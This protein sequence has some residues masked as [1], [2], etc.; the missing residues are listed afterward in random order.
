MKTL[1]QKTLF[2][3]C[4]VLFSCSITIAQNDSFYTVTTWKVV[5]PED[6][7]LAELNTL[8]K[9]FKEK[10]TN[11]NQYIASERT[12]RHLSGSDSRDLV[13]ITEYKSWNDIDAASTRQGEL[14][15]SAW[16]TEEARKAFFTKFNKYFLMHTDE[17][18]TGLNELHKN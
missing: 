15:E 8:L 18:Y 13:I 9:E 16:K 12:L 3:L 11:P 6:G 4:I 2:V 17:M 14:I 1:K 7:N 5:V 10:V